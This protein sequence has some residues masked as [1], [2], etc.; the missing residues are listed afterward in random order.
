METP[1]RSAAQVADLPPDVIAALA[2]YE[3]AVQRALRVAPTH[4]QRYRDP[5]E[6][7]DET[8][9]ARRLGRAALDHIDQVV[10]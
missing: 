8:R 6:L 7:T 9:K 1:D 10:A 3:A 5:F 4:W 2:A